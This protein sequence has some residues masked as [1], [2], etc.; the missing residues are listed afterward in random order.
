[1]LPLLFVAVVAATPG[2]GLTEARHALEVGRLDQAR[3]MIAAAIASGQGGEPVERL[4]ADLAFAS[5]KPAEALVRYED[6]LARSPTDTHLL[7][8]AAT[9]AAK[10]GDVVRAESYAKRA[11]L[12]SEPSWR[13]WNVLGAMGD[14]RKDFEAADLAYNRALAVAPDQPELLNNIGWSHLLRGDWAGAIPSLTRAVELRPDM[15]R[16]AN[17]LE[18]ASAAISENLPSRKAG[19]SDV[20]WAARLNDAGIAAEMRGE[21]ARAVAAFSQ[22]LEARGVWY[23]RAANN[24]KAAEPRR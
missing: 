17:N 9:S 15:R 7:E 20:A 11:T 1:M 21:Q 8:R 18:L 22:A 10:L 16:A 3:T 14:L 13:A 2:D 23:E 5:G 24:L 4:L 12:T 19:E 6:L